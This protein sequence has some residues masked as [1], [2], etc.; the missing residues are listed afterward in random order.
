MRKRKKKKSFIY[1]KCEIFTF[2]YRD[3][4]ELNSSQAKFSAETAKEVMNDKALKTKGDKDR[5]L[6]EKKQA[7]I[8]KF[9]EERKTLG[10]RQGRESEKLK[11]AQ[12]K[13]LADLDSI[14]EKVFVIYILFPQLLS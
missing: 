2:I 9:T 13:A 11:N 4:K 5:R 6:R 12:T 14:I 8:K 1:L 10:I 3:T 7:N